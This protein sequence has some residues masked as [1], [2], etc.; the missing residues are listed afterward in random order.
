MLEKFNQNILEVLKIIQQAGFQSW[1]VGGCVRDALLNIPFTDYDIATSATPFE[2]INVLQ[3]FEL[4]KT[5]QKYGCIKVKIDNI[6]AELTTLRCDVQN[7]GRHANVEFTKNISHDANRRDFTMN[8]IYWDGANEWFDFFNGKQDVEDNIVKFIGNASQRITEDYLRILRFLRF[9]AHYAKSINSEDFNVCITHQ[10]NLRYLSS[11]RVW[12]EW[13]KLLKGKNAYIV[14]NAMQKS[15]IA[16][17]IFGTDINL[18][19]FKK[20][21]G[22]DIVLSSRLLLSE[23]DLNYL[24]HRLQLNKHEIYKLKIADNLQRQENFRKI[25]YQYPNFAKELVYFWSA[26]F[27][28]NSDEILKQNFWQKNNLTFTLA[29]KHLIELG[30]QE[31]A[32][33]GKYLEITRN[34]WIENNFLPNHEECLNYARKLFITKS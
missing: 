14:L 1:F 34:W 7:F 28:K 5:F 33:I 26:K 2:I 6:W 25:Y 16:F 12:Q 20:F 31:S 3:N 32:N 22:T 15:G 10:E 29:G 30:C 13:Q 19:S 9:S 17:T 4:D 24:I 8:A 21:Q 23:I 11:T 18:E 27:N